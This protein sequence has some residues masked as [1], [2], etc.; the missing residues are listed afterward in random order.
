MKYGEYKNINKKKNLWNSVQLTEKQQSEIDSF[1]LKH[2][3][4]KVPTKWHK[5]YQSYTGVYHYNYFP[6]I[7]LSTALE[8]KIN[9]YRQTVFFEDKN[10]LHQLF[11]SIKDLHISKTYVSCVNGVLRNNRDNLMSSME[12]ANKKLCI[13]KRKLS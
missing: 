12:E 8:P 13:C 5:L 3:G 7:L 10:L 2:Y 9:S 1:Y 11:G 4:K 6:E